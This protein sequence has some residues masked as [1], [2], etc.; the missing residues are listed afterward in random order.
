MLSLVL[1]LLGSRGLRGI[2]EEMLSGYGGNEGWSDRI[3]LDWGTNAWAS[4]GIP[5]GTRYVC[6]CVCNNAIGVMRSLE[7]LGCWS[8]EGCFEL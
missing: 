2:L 6:I 7:K 3:G 4:G 8:L 1:T 5:R